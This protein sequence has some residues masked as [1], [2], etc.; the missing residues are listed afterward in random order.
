VD[1]TLTDDYRWRR[2]LERADPLVLAFGMAI[3]GAVFIHALRLLT[4]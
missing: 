2:F 1:K 3:A 4:K